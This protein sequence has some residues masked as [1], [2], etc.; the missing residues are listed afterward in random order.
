MAKYVAVSRLV[1]I[2]PAK[3]P[4]VKDTLG[5]ALVNVQSLA[6]VQKNAVEIKEAIASGAI[7]V[8]NLGINTDGKL[9]FTN[10]AEDNYP[11]VDATSGASIRAGVVVISRI[12]KNG[13][14]TDYLVY[15]SLTNRIAPMSLA[16]ILK[17]GSEN[18]ANGKL[19]KTST[20]DI[21]QS[22]KG[23]YPVI[24]NKVVESNASKQ[25]VKRMDGGSLENLNV[26]ICYFQRAV[27]NGKFIDLCGL[28]ISMDAD[29]TQKAAFDTIRRT[30]VSDNEHVKAK[31]VEIDDREE[32]L[33][34]IRIRESDDS[35]VIYGAFTFTV[36]D[37][38]IRRGAKIDS[39]ATRGNYDFIGIDWSGED[40]SE[41]T[42]TFVA[43]KMVNK[44][45]GN[46]ASKKACADITNKANKFLEE[47][48]IT[49]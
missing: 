23:E 15:N 30:M 39:K 28:Y 27:K 43:G 33:E 3:K 13:K 2:V 17:I 10:G 29:A 20:G 49:L 7:E 4:K 24:D 31:V 16:D 18:V 40:F 32:A 35:T 47:R 36:L 11:A 6:V 12:E 45:E 8:L 42:L 37:N 26:S 48:N 1:T 19:R 44:T 41:T 22:I 34:S 46:G 38:F 21:I 9:A 5:Y 25:S 14:L